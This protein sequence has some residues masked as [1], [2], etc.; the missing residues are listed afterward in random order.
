[1]W[2]WMIGAAGALW[3]VTIASMRV[4]G[5][6]AWEGYVNYG[7]ATC[8]LGPAASSCDGRATDGSASVCCEPLD[9]IVE[10]NLIMLPEGAETTPNKVIHGEGFELFGQS[11]RFLTRL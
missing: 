8:F 7:V 6:A 11:I 5:M 9:S 10:E 3:K 2:L 4:L 1:V